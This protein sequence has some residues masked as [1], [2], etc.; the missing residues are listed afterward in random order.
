MKV[1]PE[2]TQQASSTIEKLNVASGAFMFKW[3]DAMNN[4]EADANVTISSAVFR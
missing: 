1:T 2:A 3:L 4:N